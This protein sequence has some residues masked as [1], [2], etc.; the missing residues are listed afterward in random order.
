MWVYASKMFGTVLKLVP[1]VN[2]AS[3]APQSRIEFESGKITEPVRVRVREASKIALPKC[4]RQVILGQHIAAS[5]NLSYK[6]AIKEYPA[7]IETFIKI[8]FYK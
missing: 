6:F 4:V 2:A 7:Y 3:S 8:L 5:W 1:I